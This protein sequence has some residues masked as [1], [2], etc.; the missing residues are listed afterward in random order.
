M[1]YAG[2]R[3]EEPRIGGGGCSVNAKPEVTAPELVNIEIDG[4]ALTAPK[5]A[6]IIQAADEAGIHIPRFCYHKKLPIAANCRMCLV[7]VER[8]PKAVPA[9]ATPS[10]KA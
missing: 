8:M 10:R 7:E 2:Y 3:H 6:M 1:L 9:C 5:G 4:I